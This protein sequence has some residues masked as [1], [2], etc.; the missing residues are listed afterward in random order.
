MQRH[1]M[2]TLCGHVFELLKGEHCIT[3]ALT[4]AGDAI[5]QGKLDRFWPFRLSVRFQ[6]L[7]KASVAVKC[8]SR[9]TVPRRK[10]A[11]PKKLLLIHKKCKA[12][13]PIMCLLHAKI[14]AYSTI[15]D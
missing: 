12:F 13:T 8:R 9:C 7:A 5:D 2:L 4:Q 15:C 3:K 14:H 1:R 11:L 10:G 6:P